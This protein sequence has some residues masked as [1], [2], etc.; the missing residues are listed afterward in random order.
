MDYIPFFKAVLFILDS[1][2]QK[3]CF[4]EAN[5]EALFIQQVILSLVP[6]KLVILPYVMI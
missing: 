2:S 1:F 3:C 4:I 5:I 6:L